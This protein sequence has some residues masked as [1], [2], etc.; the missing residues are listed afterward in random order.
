MFSVCVCVCVPACV[1][2]RM[3]MNVGKFG[4]EDEIIG[5]TPRR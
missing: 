4:G 5:R 1:D 3:R 2:V